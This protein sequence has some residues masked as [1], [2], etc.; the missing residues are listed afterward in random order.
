[1]TIGSSKGAIVQVENIQWA[2]NCLYQIVDRQTEQEWTQRIPLLDPF[3]G[4]DDFLIAKEKLEINE[5]NYRNKLVG[6]Q[7]KTN[8]FNLNR[9]TCF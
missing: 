5:I 8:I 2:F 6:S 1:M 9:K 7:N 3:H 4:I